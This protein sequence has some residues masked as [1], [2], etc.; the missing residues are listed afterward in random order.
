VATLGLNTSGYISSAGIVHKGK[1][2]AGACEERFS[3]IKRDRSFP[4]NAVAFCLRSA[5]VSKEHLDAV[6]VGWNPVINLKKDFSL[7]QDANRLRGIH[8]TY[9][10]NALYGVL[11]EWGE[12]ERCMVNAFG[13]QCHFVDH[14]LAHAASACL[15]SPFEHCA[16]ATVDAFG[17]EDSM[18]MGVFDGARFQT[19]E[20]IKFPH[21]PGSFYSYITEFLGF[22]RDSDE[23]KVMALGAYAEDSLSRLFYERLRPLLNFGTKDGRFFF[24][25][26]LRFFDYYMFHRPYDF[27]A[28]EGVLGIKRRTKDAPLKDE[29]FAIASALQRC[30]EELVGCFLRHTKEKTGIEK[31]ALAGGCFMNSVYNGRL[32][33]TENIFKDVYIPPFPDDSGVAIGSALFV[34]FERFGVRGEA[35]FQNF[36]GPSITKEEALQ[37]LKKACLEF[38]SP[39]CIEEE[40]ASLVADGFIVGHAYKAME[41][42]QRALGNRSIFAD[43]RVKDIRAILNRQVKGRE[44][45]RPY[46]VSVLEDHVSEVFQCDQGFKAPFMEKVVFVRQ[47]WASKIKGCLHND[48][49]VRVHTVKEDE[50]P[51]LFRI[52]EAFYKKTG[53]PLL[54]NTS[55]NLSQMPIVATASDAIACFFTS[56]MDAL[57]LDDFLLVK[58]HVQR[59]RGR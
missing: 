20:H 31:V 59:K 46:G 41:F 23:Y 48:G 58:P 29:H 25:V 5:N 26:D 9:N 54:I 11:G 19:M 42:G 38:E 44:W 43:P 27:G 30:F 51:R 8:L 18:T 55:F 50:N 34:D 3:R 7:L 47:S 49:S 10:I 17:E 15:L 57:V 13:V 14:H 36:I 1:V 35:M 33:T 37:V 56:G 21:S 6:A 40:V 32:C 22:K 4:A 16:F 45:F 12:D 53:V 28:L 2:V 39:Q 52:L 24:Q